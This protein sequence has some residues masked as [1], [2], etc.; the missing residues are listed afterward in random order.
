MYDPEQRSIKLIASK[1]SS[2][3]H[4]TMNIITLFME[5]MKKWTEHTKITT[6][7]FTQTQ[8]I[9][10]NL[11]KKCTPWVFPSGNC[12]NMQVFVECSISFSRGPCFMQYRRTA[13]PEFWD[14]WFEMKFWTEKCLRDILQHSYCLS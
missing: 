5:P 4:A 14:L 11:K 6:S 3:C 7:N 13:L 1:L 8:S 2:S 10:V 12:Y 9:F